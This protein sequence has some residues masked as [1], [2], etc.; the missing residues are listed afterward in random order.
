MRTSYI[1]IL[2]F[3]RLP[4]FVSYRVLLKGSQSV[5]G[6]TQDKP[7]QFLCTLRLQAAYKQQSSNST[8]RTDKAESVSVARAA[9]CVLYA[10][11]MQVDW[12]E[13]NWAGD[14][15][16]VFVRS[17]SLCKLGNLLKYLVDAVLGLRTRLG[18]LEPPAATPIR[19][20][21]AGHLHPTISIGFIQGDMQLTERSANKSILFPI[22]TK[23]KESAAARPDD[24]QNS[25]LHVPTASNDLRQVTSNMMIH[26]SAP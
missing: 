1:W 26:A 4:V 9:C 6:R 20:L 23:G 21:L 17:C 25:S 24:L 3:S 10:L 16:I 22:T 13:H 15:V 2:E 14:H 19:R 11:V 18:V 5:V 12:A 8:T 7:A